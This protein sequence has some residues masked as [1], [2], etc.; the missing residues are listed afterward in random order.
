M[1]KHTDYY[2]SN[3]GSEYIYIYVGN[4]NAS[5]AVNK[6]K[7]KKYKHCEWM[8]FAWF[9][10][11]KREKSLIHAFQWV[12]FVSLAIPDVICELYFSLCS[13]ACH[14][15]VLSNV[16]CCVHRWIVSIFLSENVHINN[17]LVGVVAA[18][19][20]VGF[21]MWMNALCDA[22]S[23]SKTKHCQFSLTC[24]KFLWFL[25]VCAND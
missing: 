14:Y 13:C 3:E 6:W 17:S 1:N 16:V 8:V 25:F 19:V 12:V 21:G 23:K 5:R 24:R 22:R 20:V 11:R 15:C 18:V 4:K 7:Y 9:Y 10:K 2:T